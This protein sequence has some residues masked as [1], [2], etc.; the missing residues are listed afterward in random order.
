MTARTPARRKLVVIG[1]GM[2]GA[3]L[4][5]DVLAA[6]PAAFDVAVFG[7]EPYG[8]YNRI[9]LSNVLNGTQDAK[10]IF[11]N[12]LAWYAENGVTLHAGKRVTR[13]DRE[14]RVVYADGTEEPYD[15]L[16]FATGSK[17]FVP[18]IPGTTLHGVFVFRTLD[19]CRNIAEYA[20]GC[21]TAAV[22]GGGLLGLE[23]AK[24]L[25]T[26]DVA[27]TVVEMAPWLMSV[28]LDEAGGKVLGETIARMGIT[29]KTGAGTKEITGHTHVTGVKFADGS[30]IAADMVVVSA[31]IRPNVDLARECGVTIDRAVVVDDQMRTNDPHVFGVGECVQHRGMIYGLVAPLWE[32]T[33]VLAKVL[34]GADPA[35]AYP[36]SKIATKLKVMGVEL[37]SMGRIGDVQ[38]T[39]EVVQFSEPARRVYWKAVVRDGRVNAACLLGDLGPA[40]RL[41]EMFQKGT[42]VPDRRLELF[43]TADTQQQETSLADLPDSH[44][45]CDCNGVS[46]KAVCD[47]IR[48][49]KCTVAAVGKAT[50]AGTGCGSCKKLVKGLIE[51]VA[52][53]VKA[54]P[55]EAWYVPAVPLDKPALVAAV[56]DRG[57][58]SVSA[59]L[60][61][62]GTGED[63]KSKNGL[64]SLLKGIWNSEYVDERDARF[65]NDRVHANIQKDGTFSVV[66]RIYGGVTSADDLI[67]IGE[68]AKKYD[69]PMVKVTGGQ[70]IDLLG[71]KK[72]DL[73][74][75]W[76]DLGM[77]SGYA[78]TKAF[79][80]CKTCVGSEF[81]RYGTNDSTALG[82]AIE[83]R[84][85]GIE[86]PAKV[87]LAVSG[88]PRNCA[89]STV[90]DI[91]V[92]A[93]EGGEW[94]ISVGG[95]AG[96]S[97]RKTDVLCRVKTRDEALR[98]IGRFMQFYRE[99][100][101]WL[102][103]TY[104]F[105]PRVGIDKLRD[106]IANDSLGIGGRLDADIQASIDAYVDPW[107]ERDNPV[108]AGQFEDP[109]TVSLPVLNS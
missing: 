61:E 109:R 10:E 51:A 78:Y 81:C 72:E 80:T 93:T 87:K 68:V 8:N 15:A 85:Q 75:V 77:P 99:N 76:R 50:R 66:P 39:D 90:K 74:H 65:I 101:K 45:V 11:L 105:V 36:G 70:R 49:G 32:Q 46:K 55:A 34:T 63:E 16:V 35:A 69:V 17:P 91:G 31:G 9:L 24:G 100:A 29:A 67:R 82:I 104:D 84:F 92:I 102:E 3:R 107:L 30:E 1:N 2:A 13:V 4:V 83:R 25:M 97:V 54:D 86:F 23:A 19:D 98:V 59:V 94:E 56:K 89:E 103:R 47:A 12:P 18:P 52:G 20:K 38:P 79:R 57:L 41:M 53:G 42:P 106:V 26:H 7:D 27:V 64:A 71:V 60:R 73:P 58:R 14:R 37:A 22:I 96:A 6:D 95:A 88:C 108:Y 28:Q 62:L 43:F 33:K 5:E 40:D 21:K 44:Q 48:A